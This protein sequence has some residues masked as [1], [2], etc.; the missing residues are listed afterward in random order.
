M[1]DGHP[2]VDVVDSPVVVES[3]YPWFSEPV[4]GGTVRLVGVKPHIIQQ[5]VAI[6]GDISGTHIV[7]EVFSVPSKDP[8]HDDA[9]L[10]GFNLEVARFVNEKTG[11]IFQQAL[12]VLRPV[13]SV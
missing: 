9:I 13:E 8:G 10:C 1:S 7:L 5:E 6:A 3:F 11:S 12:G 4:Q 2:G